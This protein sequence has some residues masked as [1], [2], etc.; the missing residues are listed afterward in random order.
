MKIELDVKISAKDLYLF[1]IRQAYKG[2]QGFLSILL[3]ILVFAYAVA[4]V[5]SASTGTILIYVALGI[6]FLVYVPISLWLRVNKIMK[7]SNNALTKTLHYTFEEEAIRVA[8]EEESVDFQWENIYQMKT[9]GKHLLLY[10][11]RINAYIL[12]L[13]QVG[14]KYEELSKLAHAK[15]EKHRISMK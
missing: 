10:T 11:N 7:D 3:P 6:V 14:D 5:G 2:M 15:L 12:P 13:E 8:V 9:A 4:S 1:N